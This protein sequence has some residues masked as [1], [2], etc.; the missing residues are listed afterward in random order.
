MRLTG[1]MIEELREV[2]RKKRPSGSKLSSEL[3]DGLL[4]VAY[5]NDTAWFDAHPLVWDE[6]GEPT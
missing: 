6:L 4:I 1:E 2:R 5:R 3:L